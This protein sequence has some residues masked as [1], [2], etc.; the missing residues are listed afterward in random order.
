[1][2]FFVFVLLTNA[3]RERIISTITDEIQQKQDN[4]I[5]ILSNYDQ[6]MMEIVLEYSGLLHYEV[7]MS[8]VNV[9]AESALVESLQ[10]Q[11]IAAYQI[12]LFSQYIALETK[13]LIRLTTLGKDSEQYKRCKKAI[14]DNIT[15]S[16]LRNGS[17]QGVRVLN[18]YHLS[19]QRLSR[20]LQVV[21]S[22]IFS[23]TY[24]DCSS[25][26]TER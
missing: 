8:R 3:T 7:E 11:A 25:S 4:L 22:A 20:Q 21:I 19:N 9:R 26:V 14:K 13:G 17:Y 16:F 10:R 15:A 1:M 2:I 24:V 18:V 5:S 6:K 23:S 12:K